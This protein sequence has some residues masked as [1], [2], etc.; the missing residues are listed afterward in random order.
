[1]RKIEYPRTAFEATETEAG[2]IKKGQEKIINKAHGEAL[3][4]D[5]AIN[6]SEALVKAAEDQADKDAMELAEVREEIQGITFTSDRLKREE[7]EAYEEAQEALKRIQS[8]GT[9]D[10]HSITSGARREMIRARNAH[11]ESLHGE[12]IKDNERLDTANRNAYISDTRADYHKLEAEGRKKFA[13]ADN[14]N[15]T[16]S[17]IRKET[18]DASRRTPL[19]KEGEDEKAA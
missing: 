14:S 2:K 8:I 13:Q 11:E 9:K 17:N 16:A 10:D 4:I 7:F 19:R 3:K 12:A 5:T 6:E 1:M 18:Q 15:R